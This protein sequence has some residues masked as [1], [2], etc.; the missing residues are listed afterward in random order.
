V[1][2]DRRVWQE[3]LALVADGWGVTVIGPR[4]AGDMR[5]LRTTLDGIQV[6]RYPQRPATGLAGYL[7][8]YAPSL[9]FTTFWLI[10]TRLHGPIKVIQGCN[11]PDL[12]WTIGLLGRL[13][14]AAYVFDQHDANPELAMTKWGDRRGLSRGLLRLTVWLER[15]SY[16][17]AALVLAPNESYRNL[18]LERGGLDPTDV[19]VVRNAPDVASYRKQALGV[20][21]LPRRVGYVGVMGS[22]DGLDVLMDAWRILRSEPD[23]GDAV[24]ELVGDGESRSKLQDQASRLGV[25]DSVRFH[26]YM[27]PQAFVPILAACTVCVSPDPPTPFNDVSTMVKVIDYLALGKGLVAFDLG[28][29]RRVAG[30]AAHIV[31]DPSARGL[32]DGI[33]EVL[34]DPS[35][36][37]ALEE[38][39][40]ERVDVLELDWQVSASKLTAAYGRFKRDRRPEPGRTNGRKRSDGPA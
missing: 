39:T 1:P 35:S 5:A 32:A 28:E 34:R 38:A 29:T 21:T 6:L 18:A 8:E 30:G 22:Q 19:I 20:T 37:R 16:K 3:A 9:V 33:L 13:W 12:F 24:L 10:W 23:M 2:L 36:A 4:G 25:S 26:G 7:I 14:G 15:R 11:P 31:M 27:R 17:T 40:Q